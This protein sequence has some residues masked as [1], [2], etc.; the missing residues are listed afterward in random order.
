M[1][2]TGKE[3]EYWPPIQHHRPLK[4]NNIGKQKVNSIPNIQNARI[5]ATDV[6]PKK[7]NTQVIDNYATSR[8]PRHIMKFHSFSSLVIRFHE[9]TYNWTIPSGSE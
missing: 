4:F 9:F 8:S 5:S 6:L 1:F 7:T 3:T 2:A